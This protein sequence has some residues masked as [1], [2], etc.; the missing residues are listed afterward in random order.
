[1]GIK[2][3]PK[4]RGGYPIHDLEERRERAKRTGCETDL[5]ILRQAVE[6]PLYARF[7]RK[8]WKETSPNTEPG[9]RVTE[10]RTAHNELLVTF[11]GV[12][13]CISMAGTVLER[14]WV[15]FGTRVFLYTHTG[16]CWQC[17]ALDS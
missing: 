14:R 13:K 8:A 7:H 5:D 3:K 17:E 10:E 16:L 4:Q 11:D 6:R 1:M 2:T 9:N 15:E 12:S